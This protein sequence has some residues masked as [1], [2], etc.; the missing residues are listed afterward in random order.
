[1]L[2]NLSQIDVWGIFTFPDPCRE[3]F[4]AIIIARLSFQIHSTSR[5]TLLHI[6]FKI[7]S[8][9]NQLQ[10]KYQSLATS[11]SGQSFSAGEF[12]YGVHKQYSPA[13]Q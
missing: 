7:Q 6:R 3:A 4:A 8:I 10:K 9:S 5:Y 13:E 12:F 1:M 11:Y 2:G